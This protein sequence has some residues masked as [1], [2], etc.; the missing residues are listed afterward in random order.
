MHLEELYAAATK[1]LSTSS[2]LDDS[3]LS[4]QLL[5]HFYPLD[6][7][8]YLRASIDGRHFVR[9]QRVNLTEPP[10]DAFIR[11]MVEAIE[12]DCQ[13]LLHHHPHH[14]HY[15]NVMGIAMH[16]YAETGLEM[17]IYLPGLLYLF[18]EIAV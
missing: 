2:T 17:L 18:L 10:L 5:F 11:S 6:S 14:D 13:S 7:D 4:Q 1:P 16:L 8:N 12:Q 3:M 9:P 15:D